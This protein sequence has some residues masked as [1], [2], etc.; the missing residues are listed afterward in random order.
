VTVAAFPDATPNFSVSA[1]VRINEY[2]QGS[3]NDDGWGTIV[4][5][6]NSG[7]WEFNVDKLTASPGLNFG[8]WRGPNGGDYNWYTCYCLGLGQWTQF[9]AVVDGSRMAFDAYVNGELRNTT[10]FAQNIVPGSA[11]LTMGEAPWG[12]RYLVGDVDDIAVYGRALV[13]AEVSELYEHPPVAP[14]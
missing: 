13:P 7:G 1:W 8:F 10:A 4:S 9:S 6:E 3:T 2:T 5:T 11:M 12:T 14:P